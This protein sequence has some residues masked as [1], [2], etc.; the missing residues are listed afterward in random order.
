ML[1]QCG[2]GAC[3]AED[4]ARSFLSGG[5]DSRCIVSAL[6]ELGRQTA[7]VAFDVPH[8]P[9]RR[10]ADKFSEVIGSRHIVL[11]GRAGYAPHELLKYRRNERSW[12]TDQTTAYPQLVF[13]GD[14]GS[15]GVGFVYMDERLTQMLRAGRTREAVESYLGRHQL[16][17]KIFK[18]EIYRQLSGVV[19][20]GVLEELTRINT[21][22][23]AKAFYFFL[24][25]ND[26]R[27]HLYQFVYEDIDIRRVEYLL[28][29]YD[30]LFVE[31]LA[32]APV[33]WF[34]AHRF[35]HLWLSRFPKETTQVPWQ[36]Y[37]GHLPC[38]IPGIAI[39]KTQWDATYK[40]Y[41]PYQSAKLAQCRTALMQPR[42][43]APYI[44]HPAIWLA[45]LAQRFGR[46]D[47][48]SAIDAF[49]KFYSYFNRCNS[50]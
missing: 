40:D 22:D 8:S 33:D 15:V 16:P 29:F 14:G 7:T 32:S 9:D 46:R 35:Y 41:I 45:Y 20:D 31:Q 11:P 38:P 27:R 18:P 25:K 26:Q 48:R 6:T 23:P 4:S 37:P 30:G 42:F 5:L 39:D 28:P 47:C 10:I 21:S 13:S 44:R 43:P 24:M 19:F 2:G 34:L 17:R 49:L 50:N 3:G 1:P 36:T 12:L